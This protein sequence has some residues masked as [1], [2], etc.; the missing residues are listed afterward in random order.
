MF[1][2]GFKTFPGLN[3]LTCSFRVH[4]VLFHFFSFS[5]PPFRPLSPSSLLC[6]SVYSQ[7]RAIHLG[8]WLFFSC[9]QYCLSVRAAL[10]CPLCSVSHP[11]DPALH[12]HTNT[13][14]HT[15]TYTHTEV[16]NLLIHTVHHPHD[17]A[18][19]SIDR[20]REYVM[21]SVPGREGANLYL[22]DKKGGQANYGLNKGRGGGCSCQ[23]DRP[24]Y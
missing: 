7:M 5:I 12:T 22:P 16:H 21:A 10:P 20:E 8:A 2:V 15:Q 3:L 18:S 19:T 9:L 14:T 23:K 11:F 13:R 1:V 4:I 24:S 17:P 6:R